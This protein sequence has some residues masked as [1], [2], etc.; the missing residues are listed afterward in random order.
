MK[1]TLLQET[2]VTRLLFTKWYL[3]ETGIILHKPVCQFLYHQD[4]ALLK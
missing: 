1:K 2:E 4:S 3:I